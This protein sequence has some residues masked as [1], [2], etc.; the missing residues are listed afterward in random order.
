M[1]VCVFM[2]MNGSARIEIIIEVMVCRQMLYVRLGD[3][4]A[5]SLSTKPELNAN[6]HKALPV[7]F[8]TYIIYRVFKE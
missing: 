5:S 3:P 1:S 6:E 2:C 4:C 7:L 8:S